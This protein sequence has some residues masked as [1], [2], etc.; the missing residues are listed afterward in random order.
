MSYISIPSPLVQEKA[1]VLDIKRGSW[2]KKRGKLESRYT[3]WVMGFCDRLDY[4][5]DRRAT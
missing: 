4:K 1:I 5:D 2:K 3:C